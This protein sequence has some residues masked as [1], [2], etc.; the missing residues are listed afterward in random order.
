MVNQARERNSQS[1]LAMRV[2]TKTGKLFIVFVKVKFVGQPRY[3]RMA[4]SQV[5]EF[6]P[7]KKNVYGVL[8]AAFLSNESKNICV[9]DR[10][11]AVS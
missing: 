3:V 8:G 7:K 5:K 6:L 4:A 1:D 2:G 9:K 11:A 10:G